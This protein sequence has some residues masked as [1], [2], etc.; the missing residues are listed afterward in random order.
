MLY[1]IVKLII[2]SLKLKEHI[3]VIHKLLSNI[4]C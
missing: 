2:L 4:D 1:I 3:I